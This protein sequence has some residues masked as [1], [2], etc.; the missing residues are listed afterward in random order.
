MKIV[1]AIFTSLLVSASAYA[2]FGGEI[3]SDPLVEQN[4]GTTVGQ[5]TTS[6]NT[7]AAIL[8]ADQ[9]TAPSVTT[10]GGAGLFQAVVGF[11]DVLH[12]DFNNTVN[13]QVFNAVFPGWTRL[14][15]DAIP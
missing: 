14:P 13:A 12:A 4:T 8:T 6:D 9:T 11:L 10:G 15:L 5:L 7:L 2:Q 3:V 1:I